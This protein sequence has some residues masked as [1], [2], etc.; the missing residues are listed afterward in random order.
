MTGP[1]LE[2]RSLVKEYEQAGGRVRALCLDSLTAGKGEAIA[3][4][5]PSGSGKTTLLHLLAGLIAPSGG[6]VRFGGHDPAAPDDNA[7][8]RAANVGYVFQDL[9]LLPDFDVLENLLIAAEIS[10]IPLNTA[11]ERAFTLLER[12]KLG[13][14]LRHR[15]AKL[16][17]GEQQRAAI[18][19]AVIHKPPLILADEPT[20]SLDSVN[21]ENVMNLLMELCSGSLLIVATH[22]EAVKKRFP[23]IV[24]LRKT[25]GLACA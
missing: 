10:Q 12:L 9:N 15:P 24:E 7:R 17:L 16:S 13:D 2:I 21:A 25:E 19:R 6:S 20:A 18:A 23:R 8:W 22:D 4:T 5:G 3:V 1:L 11:Y 14:R